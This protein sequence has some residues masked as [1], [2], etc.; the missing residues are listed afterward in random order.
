MG[1]FRSGDEKELVTLTLNGESEWWMLQQVVVG[2]L[3][4]FP[5]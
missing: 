1:H 3:Q 5:G 2:G 4:S